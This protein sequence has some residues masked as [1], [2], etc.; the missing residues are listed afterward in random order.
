MSGEIEKVEPSALTIHEERAVKFF[1]LDALGHAEADAEFDEQEF[2]AKVLEDCRDSDPKVRQR[3]QEFLWKIKK[4]AAIYSGRIGKGRQESIN[5]D[6]QGNK[7]KTVVTTQG[8]I[9]R[10]SKENPHVAQSTPHR[11]LN[12]RPINDP[13]AV[14]SGQAG[15]GTSDESPTIGDGQSEEIGSSSGEAHSDDGRE[16]HPE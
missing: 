1:S 9:A 13:E 5:T 15:G 16:E 3:A 4:D 7:W 10:L 11:V 8:I 12:S 2:F 14:D 6:A